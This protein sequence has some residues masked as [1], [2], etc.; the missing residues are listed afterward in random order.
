[1]KKWLL[2]L[3][4]LTV[5]IAPASA[6]A[7]AASTPTPTPFPIK[8]W[9]LEE[10]QVDGSTVTVLLQVYAGIDVRVTLDGRGPDQVNASPPIL[11]FIF[12]NVTPGQ[13]TIEVWDMVS[14]N[15]TAVVVVGR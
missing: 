10:I 4:G 15:E 5:T 13:H 11:E 1:M 14:H 12:Q 6:C 8:E 2:P 9:N 7:S 3:I